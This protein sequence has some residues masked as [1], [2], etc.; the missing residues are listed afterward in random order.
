M[1]PPNVPVTRRIKRIS[2][3]QLG[4]ML[5]LL[6]GII[7]LLAIPFFLFIASMSSQLPSDQ[8]GPLMAMGTGAAFFAPILYGVI[9]FII[10]VIGAFI[11]NLVARWAGGIE[12]EL[13]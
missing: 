10:G 12:I 4:K 8:R 2:S 1:T 3:L 5:A 9:G 11:Y 6:Y 7:G 13:E